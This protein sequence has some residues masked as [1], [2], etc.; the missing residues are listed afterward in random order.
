MPPAARANDSDDSRGGDKY[1][2]PP[3]APCATPRNTRSLRDLL[4]LLLT[5]RAI[6][7]AVSQSTR[8]PRLPM[9]AI[10]CAFGLM[11]LILLPGA[12]ATNGPCSTEAGVLLATYAHKGHMIPPGSWPDP[13][14][15]TAGIGGVP[16]PDTSTL[17]AFHPEGHPEPRP[18]MRLAREPEGWLRCDRSDFTPA[19]LKQIYN[20]VRKHD[21][22]FA[23]SLG[24][25]PG[26]SGELGPMRI[27]LVDESVVLAQ[28]RRRHSAAEAAIQD[29]KCNELKTPAIIV[30]SVS[31]RH[32]LNT[33]MPGKKDADGNWTD[34]R[35]CV[36]ARPLNE[37]CIPDPYVPHPLTRCS[38]RWEP[39]HA[40]PS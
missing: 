40:S 24:D 20:V 26:Y 16:D 17:A 19:R 8:G 9:A 14:P 28:A 11:I 36:D 38:N 25:L 5:G 10:A 31:A 37:H 13:L 27:P 15:H 29:E 12:R 21:H 34:R 23:R 33:T 18:D 3:E 30:P 7:T 35:F 22:V 32:A 39:A 1:T 4:T 6:T 2:T